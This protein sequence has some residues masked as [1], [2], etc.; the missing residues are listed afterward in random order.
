[1]N[2]FPS[3]HNPASRALTGKYKAELHNTD[4]LVQGHFTLQKL[5]WTQKDHEPR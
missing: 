5:C 3:A 4:L 2:H 1:M